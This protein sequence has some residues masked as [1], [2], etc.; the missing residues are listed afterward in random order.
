MDWPRQSPTNLRIA[1]RLD[2][3]LYLSIFYARCY[4]YN[5]TEAY[6]HNLNSVNISVRIFGIYRVGT[7]SW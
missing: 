5:K 4:R 1:H 2:V 3:S 7:V 6:T